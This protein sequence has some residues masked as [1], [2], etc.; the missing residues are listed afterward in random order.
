MNKFFSVVIK[1]WLPLAVGLTVL[2]M[3]IFVM[4]QQA[5]R[6]TANEPQAQT[7]RDIAQTLNKGEKYTVPAIV[8]LD[9]SLLP[10]V[11]TTDGTGKVI[12]SS[13]TLNGTPAIPPLGILTSSLPNGENRVTWQPKAGVRLATVVVPY[14]DGFVVVGRNLH[15]VERLAQLEL[16]LIAMGWAMSLLGTLAAVAF[17]NMFDKKR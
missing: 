13:A 12:S 7:A 17:V 4:L 16:K 6:L 1:R 15:D 2:S 10:F 5:I 14:K 8:D 3:T 11:I 9:T